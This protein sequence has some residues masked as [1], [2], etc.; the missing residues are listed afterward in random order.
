M[1]DRLLSL[2]ISMAATPGVFAL[3]VGSG[4]SRRAGIRTGWEITLEEG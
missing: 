2:S 1:I 4:V 3:L